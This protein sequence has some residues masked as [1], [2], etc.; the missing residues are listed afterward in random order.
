MLDRAAT[1]QAP[2][3]QP[4]LISRV[5]YS[6]APFAE[7]QEKCKKGECEEYGQKKKVEEE[8]KKEKTDKRKQSRRVKEAEWWKS[9]WEVASLLS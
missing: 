8:E 9:P 7:K 2:S 5:V 4:V 1:L 3:P 6:S